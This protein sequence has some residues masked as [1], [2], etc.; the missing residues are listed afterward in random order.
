MSSS[1][2]QKTSA[3]EQAY[4]APPAEEGGP[5]V[6]TRAQERGGPALK[7]G[8]LNPDNYYAERDVGARQEKDEA[9]KDTE[10]TDPTF[11]PKSGGGQ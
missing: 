1:Q 5:A 8:A 11:E 3:E 4:V 10:K 6:T 2:Q 9:Q 7:P